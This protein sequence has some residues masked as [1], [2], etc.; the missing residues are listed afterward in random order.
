MAHAS[1]VRAQLQE[2]VKA[3]SQGSPE[4]N[5]SGLS[6]RLMQILARDQS[7]RTNQFEVQ[8]R[9]DG[10]IEKAHI[11]NKDALADALQLRLDDL[12]KITYKWIPEVLS[13]LLELSERPIERT[14]PQNLKSLGPKPASPPLTW[15]DIV[16]EDPLEED[17]SIWRTI[18]YAADDSDEG[19]S[20]GDQ[21]DLS[22][23]IGETVS[24]HEATSEFDI[25]L[26][27]IDVDPKS[28]DGLAVIQKWQAETNDNARSKETRLCSEYRL[29]RETIF[30]LLGLPST[31]F[32]N[33]LDGKI[34]TDPTAWSRFT[35][36]EALMDLL[37]V[38]MRLGSELNLV[39]R[40][41]VLD[42]ISSTAQTFQFVLTRRLHEAER[43]LHELQSE[44]SSSHGDVVPS[45][46]ALEEQIFSRCRLIYP[47][48][49]VRTVL[50]SSSSSER[51]RKILEELYDQ[52]CANQSVGDEESYESVAWDF[53]ECL[54]TYLEPISEWMQTGEI[55]E[56]KQ[57]LFI[58]KISNQVPLHSI[59][60][61]QFRL[62]EKTPG[63][64][65][66]PSFLQTYTKRIFNTGKTLHFLQRMN[67]DS[68]H[69][70]VSQLPSQIPLSFESVCK[71]VDPNNLSP[72]PEL[73][74]AAFTHWVESK[75]RAASILLK[76]HLSDSQNNL[77]TSLDALDHIYLFRNTASTIEILH[78]LFDQLDRGKNPWSDTLTLTEL[79]HDSFS[80]TPCIDLN[81]LHIHISPQPLNTPKAPRSITS[82]SILQWTYNLP[83]PVSNILQ[84][85]TYPIYQKINTILTQLHRAQHLLARPLRHFLP[86]YPQSSTSS[87][88]HQNNHILSLR[89]KLIWLTS[90][91]L[92]HMTTLVLPLASTSLRRSLLH[93][94]EAAGDIDAMV[95]A[96]AAYVARI[97]DGCFVSAR[98]RAL[99]RTLLAILDL[100]VVFVDVCRA[101]SSS[102]TT[103]TTTTT[104]T[105]TAP[106]P[107]D[108]DD[109]ED[110]DHDNEDDDNDNEDG[111]KLTSTDTN[112][113]TGTILDQKLIQLNTTYTHLLAIFTAGVHSVS[114]GG[115]GGGT[116][117]TF[118]SSSN[119]T[120]AA[121]A[122]ASAY[123]DSNNDGNVAETWAILAGRLG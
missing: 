108:D 84:P 48:R 18:D 73:F 35:S 54:S 85:S 12:S 62:V 93:N 61:G 114:R 8:S 20:L 105:T 15:A 95:A 5:V 16:A 96:H 110:D 72:F 104:T 69:S 91:L 87:P 52:V 97:E 113:T 49:L 101:A 123:E 103:S 22:H 55:P 102:S 120:T 115:G 94:R 60:H 7:A 92:S 67:S 40:Y 39:R 34:S 17:P 109:N 47:A 6:G 64:V 77:S 32:R 66:T 81:S 80:Q 26:L 28:L 117:T 68:S 29:V 83:W 88:H 33:D 119:S 82:L 89:T 41:I 51:P 70:I 19:E 1:N 2:L 63:Q 4:T 44:F 86:I 118:N 27:A 75:H 98:H 79:A 50:A 56:Q 3:H 38:F 121:S 106:S 57:L 112:A 31:V 14:R 99:H 111:N 25:G 116:T 45:L 11:L 76:T 46:L 53:L 10:L 74:T 36:S 59:W 78:P 37:Q 71:C 43:V 58:E 24:T 100:V 107:Q 65:D 42:E 90:S 9:F 13:L 21:V 122:S 23:D 30:M